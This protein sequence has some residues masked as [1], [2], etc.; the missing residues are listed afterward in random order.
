MKKYTITALVLTL[1]AGVC[2]ALIASINLLTAPIITKNNDEKKSKL[3]AQIFETFDL[4]HS[5]IISEGFSSDFIEENIIACDKDG[6]VLGWIFTVSGS[7]AYGQIVLLVG[8]NIDEK[9]EGVRFIT[10]GQS[11]SSETE[12]HL[13]TQYKDDMSMDDVLDLDLSKS[14]VTAGATYA[15]KL[16]RELVSAAFTEVAVTNKGGAN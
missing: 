7:N 13:N 12:K 4:E 8:I 3:C 1:I 15:S 9:L 16:I 11:F 10:N 6:N 2:A 5:T 14:D